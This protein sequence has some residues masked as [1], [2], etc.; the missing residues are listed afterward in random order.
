MTSKLDNE[1]PDSRISDLYTDSGGEY[2]SSTFKVACP[3][4]G[5]T[6]KF[7]NAESPEENDLAEKTNE[8]AFN[9]IRVYMTLSGLPSN[10]WGYCFKYAMHVYNNTR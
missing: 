8:Y 9:K 1:L 4:R 10:L 3:S 2:A 6:Q 5:I 7:T